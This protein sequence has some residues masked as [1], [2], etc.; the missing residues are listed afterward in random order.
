[1]STELSTCSG[2]RAGTGLIRSRASSPR[3]SATC[4]SAG[5]FRGA[6]DVPHRASRARPVPAPVRGGSA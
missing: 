6:E 3:S 5:R 1:M 4:E 2:H